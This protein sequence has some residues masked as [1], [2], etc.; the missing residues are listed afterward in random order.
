MATELSWMPCGGDVM[1]EECMGTEWGQGGVGG[2]L[3]ARSWAD[4]W[5]I[6]D[7]N[8]RKLDKL[9]A[10]EFRMLSWP[11]GSPGVKVRVKVATVF[12][13]GSEVFVLLSGCKPG[14]KHL[15]LCSQ[16]QCWKGKIRETHISICMWT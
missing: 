7:P 1:A 16:A 11:K 3:M 15:R 10:R 13:T 6:W 2:E 5:S 4:S 12:N 8:L 9:D 14:R